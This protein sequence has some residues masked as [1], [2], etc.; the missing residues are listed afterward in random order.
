MSAKMD[1]LD[2]LKIKVI[3]KEG[4]DTII[5]IHDTTN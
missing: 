4:E 2:L 1:P 3:W 5:S